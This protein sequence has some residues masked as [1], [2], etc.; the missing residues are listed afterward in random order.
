MKA[1]QSLATQTPA[2]GKKTATATPPPISLKPVSNP[3]TDQAVPVLMYHHI[4]PN[5]NN[6][7]AISPSTFDQQMKWLHDNGYHAITMTQFIEFVRAGK[8]LPDKPVLITFDDGRSNQL[9]YGVPILEK[10]GFTATFFVVKKW[11]D[12]PSTSFMHKAQLYSLVKAGYDVE[13]HT[14]SHT[15]IVR[16][17]SEDYALMK[18]RLWGETNGMLVWL[19]KVTG[20]PVLALA[21]P[22]GGVDK[23]SGRLAEEAGYEVAFTTATGCARFGSDPEL[24]PRWN[25]GARGLRFSSFV[26]I[27]TKAQAA[28]KP[29]ASAPAT[30]TP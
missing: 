24:V 10:Y 2:P 5:P 9:T 25:A 18:D 17:K 22:G 20:K 7:I 26:A 6:F 23:L 13:S 30:K 11:V 15:F 8:R 3:A 4:M 19:Q 1:K 14:N 16:S 28:S 29:R 27:F 12:S 21:Y